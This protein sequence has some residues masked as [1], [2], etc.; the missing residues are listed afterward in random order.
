MLY[1]FIYIVHTYIYNIYICIHVSHQSFPKNRPNEPL[2]VQCRDEPLRVQCR[3]FPPKASAHQVS[4]PNR[5]HANG[6]VFQG[7]HRHCLWMRVG[8]YFFQ[9]TYQVLVQ[10]ARKMAWIDPQP[11]IKNQVLKL[12]LFWPQRPSHHFII[13]SQIRHP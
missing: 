6:I 5:S 9:S 12:V 8:C 3:F 1:I 2:R 7:T 4:D 10:H 13:Q 11:K